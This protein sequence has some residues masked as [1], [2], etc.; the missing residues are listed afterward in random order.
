MTE[1]S[2]P[3]VLHADLAEPADR[4][5]LRRIGLIALHVLIA[6]HLAAL[7]LAPATIP[8][9][10][11][12][13]RT[14]FR[15]VE[16]YLQ[17]LNLNHGYHYFAPDPGESRLLEYELEDGTVGRFPDKSIEPRL[18]YHRYFM[19]SE[20]QPMESADR[21]VAAKHYAAL[22]AGIE[23]HTEQPVVEVREVIHRLARPQFIR[24][25]FKLSDPEQYVIRPVWPTPEA[26]E[27]L[28]VP[29]SESD[30]LPLPL[31]EADE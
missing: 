25:G 20:S 11:Q 19:L 10:S 2:A 7:V 5:R 26:P 23:K 8:P 13:Q 28:V 31:P 16:T 18:L 27:R 22:A 30:V 4:P 24:A 6:F 29:R 12:L 15:G 1:P 3:A 14:A 17:M 21:D 9:S